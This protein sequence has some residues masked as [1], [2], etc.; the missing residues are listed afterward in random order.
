M[1]YTHPV[2]SAT[3]HLTASM[4]VIDPV[5]IKVLLIH[6]KATGKLMF[7]GG[8]VDPDEA[9][10][11]AAL[12]EV[13]EETGIHAWIECQ[14]RIELPGMSWAATPWL[15]FE[16]P[17]PA[18]PDRGLGKPAEPE[19]AHLDLLFIGSASSDD[20]PTALESEV[21][22]AIWA[23][24]ALLHTMDVRAEVPE[25]A[26]RAFTMLKNDA[27]CIGVTCGYGGRW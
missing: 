26:I 24:I 3:R 27:A 17:A 14:P 25:V 18:K 19:H 16:I 4:V 12:R 15:T 10:G 5:A 2:T 20:R 13:L 9:P 11:E 6:H 22:S 1:T 21:S 23:D 7:P 8:H